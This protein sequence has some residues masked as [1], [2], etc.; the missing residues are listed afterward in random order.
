MGNQ[1]TDNGPFPK[2]V[3]PESVFPRRIFR[4]MG[5]DEDTQEVQTPV[6]TDSPQ[7]P[8]EIKAYEQNNQPTV[9]ENRYMF[10]WETEKDDQPTGSDENVF[11]LTG[12]DKLK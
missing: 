5:D 12:R 3:F 6:K 1:N 9:K 10:P 4:W 2:S 7:F 11:D 8:W